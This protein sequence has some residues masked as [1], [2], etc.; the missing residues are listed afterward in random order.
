M[1]TVNEVHVTGTFDSLKNISGSLT[2]LTTL[3]GAINNKLRISG[4]G[5]L[6]TVLDRTAIHYAT[7]ANWNAEP[8]LVGEA[9]HV[10]IYSDYTRVE[11]DQ[12][13]VSYIPALKV[14]DGETLLIDSPFLISGD[15]QEFIDH[16]NNQSIHVSTYDRSTWNE[17]VTISADESD[18]N[19]LFSF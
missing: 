8:E 3:T 10:Y 14:G 15:D 5:S 7:T 1:P 18:E 9:G 19:L 16:I 13:N 6:P 12:G 17:K 11:D 4:R 2:N